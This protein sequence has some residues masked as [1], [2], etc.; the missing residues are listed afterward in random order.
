MKFRLTHLSFSRW[1]NPVWLQI[2]KSLLIEAIWWPVKCTEYKD[3]PLNGKQAA[4][5]VQQCRNAPRDWWVGKFVKVEI[6]SSKLLHNDVLV[7]EEKDQTEEEDLRLVVGEVVGMSETGFVLRISG[8]E[9]ET[10]SVDNFVSG[11]Y[12]CW[13]L[14][15][16]GYLNLVLC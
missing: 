3:G 5:L 11:G 9:N 16:E 13:L 10:V 1:R 4:D 8:D 6:P 15:K 7:K 2:S 12:K 14:L